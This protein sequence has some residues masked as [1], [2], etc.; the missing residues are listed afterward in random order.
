[1]CFSRSWRRSHSACWGPTANGAPGVA[2]A[3][4]AAADVGQLDDTAVLLDEPGGARVGDEVAHPAERV[5]E[6]GREQLVEAELRHELVRAQPSALVDRSQEA[7][8]VAEAVSRDGPHT[9]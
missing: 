7:M 1:M 2:G 6:V 8:R 9:R 3:D 5:L 4:V